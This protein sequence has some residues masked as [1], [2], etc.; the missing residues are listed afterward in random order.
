MWNLGRGSDG[1]RRRKSGFAPTQGEAVTLLKQLAGREVNG[2]LLTTSTPTVARYLE[3]WY[4]TNTDAWTPSTR[5]GYRD[6]ID[7]FLVP[8]FGS[9]RLPTAADDALLRL[10][11]MRAI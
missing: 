9:L 11:K 5:R 3:D 1:K 4:A 2:Q 8:A 7:R 10:K 6:A